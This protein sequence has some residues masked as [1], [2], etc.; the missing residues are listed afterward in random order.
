MSLSTSTKV[1]RPMPAANV[2]N[3]PPVLNFLMFKNETIVTAGFE[4]LQGQLTV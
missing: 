1:L 4:F 3:F 2:L